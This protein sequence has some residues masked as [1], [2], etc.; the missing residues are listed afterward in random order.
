MEPLE[1]SGQLGV[2]IEAEWQRVTDLLSSKESA[3]WTLAVVEAHKIFA[4]VLSEVS[5]GESFEDRLQNAGSLFG[6]IDGI[7]YAHTLFE[8]ITVSHPGFTLRKVDAEAAVEDLLEGIL[9]MTGR[10]FEERHRTDRV[11]TQLNYFW[12]HHPTFLAWLI[13]SVLIFV[14][15]VWVLAETLVGHFIVRLAIGFE[16]F[17]IGWQGLLV[18]LL[19]ALIFAVLL[20]YWLIGRQRR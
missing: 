1:S 11:M 20:S 17:V 7:L 19:L 15:I 10:D 9:D 5:Y 8:R 12:I 4:Q 2:E 6:Q 18:G 14:G 13:A 3:S 16:R